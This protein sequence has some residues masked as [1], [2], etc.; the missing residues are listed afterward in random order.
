[1]KPKILDTQEIYSGFFDLRQDLLENADGLTLSFTSLHMP[2]SV[3]VLAQTPNGLWIL[4]REY[5][6]P[7]GEVLL[8]PPGG[9]ID[10]GEDPLTAAKRELHEETGYYAEELQILG[11]CH[12]FPGICSQKIYYIL[13]KNAEKKGEQKL[14]P[15]E[16]IEV[17]LKTDAELLSEMQT[18]SRV[19]GNLCTALWYLHK[20]K[21]KDGILPCQ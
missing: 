11:S 6:H 12:P 17:E 1:M 7:T 10:E 4:N 14:E 8:G 2:S 9:R 21:E 16:F 20:N 19:D 15:F 3:V 18:S 5:R 13:A